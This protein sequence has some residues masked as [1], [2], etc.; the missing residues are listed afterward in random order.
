MNNKG[1]ILT[2]TLIVSAVVLTTLVLIYSQ[3]AR[4]N[5]NYTDALYYNTV[6]NIY[7]LNQVSNYLGEI[8][9]LES[10]YNNLNMYIDITDCNNSIYPNKSYCTSLMKATNIKTLLFTYN[11]KIAIVGECTFYDG[12]GIV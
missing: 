1:F 9:Q 12:S 2:E 5:S 8:N 3:F 7:S 10:L 6:S 11:S 4:I